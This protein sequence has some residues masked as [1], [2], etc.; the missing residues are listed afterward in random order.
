MT[1]YGILRSSIPSGFYGRCITRAELNDL[2]SEGYHVP[3][4]SIVVRAIDDC[5]Y[6]GRVYRP[7]E[8]GN[9]YRAIEN[10]RVATS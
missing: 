6:I 3:R 9:G 7:S 4:T 10:I 1:F 2:K 5:D 8:C